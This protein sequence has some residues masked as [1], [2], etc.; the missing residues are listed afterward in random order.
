MAWPGS[1]PRAPRG[2]T[3]VLSLWLDSE[4]VLVPSGLEPALGEGTGGLVWAEGA[5][6]PVLRPRERVF[7][8][9]GDGQPAGLAPGYPGAA[10][11]VTQERWPERSGTF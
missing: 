10:E 5:C 11:G 8:P 1:A 2:L 3:R 4:E 6:R 9:Q 7:A